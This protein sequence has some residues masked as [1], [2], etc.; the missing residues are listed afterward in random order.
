MSLKSLS[1]LNNLSGKR[2]LVRVDFNVPIKGRRVIDNS[3]LVAA[4][5]TIRF[6]EKKGVRSI[7]LLAHLG[8]PDG[9][10]VSDLSLKPVAKELQKLLRQ[11]INF[12]S[13]DNFEKNQSIGI[14]LLENI[15]FFKEEETGDRVFA[16]RLVK[17]G[18][19]FVNEAFSASHHV[20]ASLVTITK[21]LPVYAGLGLEQEVFYLSK[22]INQVA[23]PAVAIIGGA[24]VEDKL[25]VI[26]YLAKN[27]DHL[28]IGGL[29]A[30]N[31][32]KAQGLNIGQSLYNKI[33]L[34]EAK[35][36]FKKYSRK[37]ILPSDVVVDVVGTKKKE[38]TKTLINK[39]KSKHNILDVGPQTAAEFAGVIK[40]AR[41]VF[42]A[43]PLGNTDLKVYS[44]GTLAVGRVASARARGRALVVIGGGDTVAFFHTHKLWVDHYSTAG[45]ALL[46]FLSGEILPALKVLGYK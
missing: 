46:K 12:C 19:F 22:L 7:I 29:V 20:S 15:R 27:F 8:R 4:L 3:R 30:N 26:N 14:S 6:L 36:I 25:P 33:F 42:W 13:L 23:R 28:L 37:I 17:L 24:K 41:T 40:K 31:F 38:T 21:Y 16:K 11:K 44:H 9:Q 39:I 45:G 10:V 43:G 35:K 1:Q 32:I 18:D 34:T 2:A 5:P